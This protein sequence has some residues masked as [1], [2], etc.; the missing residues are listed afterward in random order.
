MWEAYDMGNEDMLWAGIPF[1]AGISGFQRAPCGAVSASAVCLGLRYRAPLSD[2]EKAKQ[3]RASARLY[4]GRLVTDFNK[5]FGD[6]TCRE[7]LGIDFNKPGAYQEFRESGLWKEK[8]DKYVDFIIEK[9]YEYE[10]GKT[11]DAPS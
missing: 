4:A 6:I 10:D 11:E 8:C 9:L 2:R 1:M 5:Q 7:L 3:G